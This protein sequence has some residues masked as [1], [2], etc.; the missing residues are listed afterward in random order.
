[1]SDPKRITNEEA[2]AAFDPERDNEAVYDAEVAPLIDQL[3]EVCRRRGIP[4]FLVA[5]FSEYGLASW[6]SLPPGCHGAFQPLARTMDIQGQ[7]AAQAAAGP[8]G[9]N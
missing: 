4:M 3:Q 1:M 8:R 6:F 7:L 9:E 5:Q 2:C